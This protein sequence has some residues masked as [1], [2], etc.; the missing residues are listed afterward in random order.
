MAYA[1]RSD[2]D[3]VDCGPGKDTV[4]ATRGKDRVRRCERIRR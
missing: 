2:R 1:K 4:F 3:R